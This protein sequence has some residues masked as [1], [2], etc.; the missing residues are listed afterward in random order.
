ME[1]NATH[2]NAIAFGR[3]AFKRAMRECI[4]WTNE[5][6]NSEG[7]FDPQS[8][9]A[10][11]ALADEFMDI[12]ADTLADGELYLPEAYRQAGHDFALTCEGHGSGFWDCPEIYGQNNADAMTAT[13]EAIYI[14][15]CASDE[16]DRLD[17]EYD[18]DVTCGYYGGA[19][20]LAEAV[21]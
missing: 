17:Q 16:D 11:D 4:L 9:A 13:C 6:E 10:L 14:E 8:V 3:E 2:S 5:R 20:S 15:T 12:H 21:K 18:V 7:R 19:K 1:L